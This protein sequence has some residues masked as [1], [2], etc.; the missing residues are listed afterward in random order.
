MLELRPHQITARDQARE[1]LRAG[2]RGVVI[3]AP[4]G[5]GKTVTAADIIRLGLERGTKTL[6]L[7]HREELI[8]Q[9]SDKLR[10]AELPHGIIMAGRASNP[11]I[12]TQVASVQ[13]LVRRMDRLSFRPNLIIIDECHLSRAKS[14]DD[15][16]KFYG[17]PFILGLS[18]TPLRLDGKP[19]GVSSG[20]FFDAMVQ[21][22][23]T[24]ELIAEGYLS[25]FKYYAPSRPDLKNVHV[26]G[27]EYNQQELAAQIDRPQIVGDAIE[28]W[29]KLA[30]GRSTLVFAVSVEHAEH[31]A[32][33]FR[34]IGVTAACV[35]GDTPKEERRRVMR[36]FKAGLI[37]V[38]VNCALYIE[39]MDAPIIRCIVDLAPTKSLTRFLQK[40][41]RGLRTNPGKRECIISDHAGN[42]FEHG[43][44]DEL[45]Q[46]SLEADPDA[47]KKRAAV[48]VMRNLQCKRCFAVFAPVLMKCPQCGL[49]VVIK[50]REVDEV[51]GSLDEVTS[52][53]IA[54][55]RA[56]DARIEVATADSREALLE[57]ARRRGFKPTWVD[58][59]LRGRAQKD[60][61]KR[62][63]D[64][65]QGR[66][67][68]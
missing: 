43:L 25:P 24:A 47:K 16:V 62:A 19:L 59:I 58:M 41:G 51:A 56:L 7:A 60:L 4:T 53:M 10:E 50:S 2:K 63:G 67:A 18:A 5:F 26:Q 35:S 12:P 55:K 36:E 40:I 68:V 14:Y 49:E 3:V 15:V 42:V 48:A 38:L 8:T 21:T 61:A 33:K 9:A 30:A 31:V 52:E 66:L 17:T 22:V 34:E 37:M 11:M 1:L 13:T 27:G 44:P 28:H 23:G 45:H 46:W 20:G 54:N 39:G 57:V 29:I 32:Q 64:M 6:F 65:R